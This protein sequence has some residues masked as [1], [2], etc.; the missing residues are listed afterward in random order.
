VQLGYSLP[1]SDV[2]QEFTEFSG[3]RYLERRVPSDISNIGTEYRVT[4]MLHPDWMMGGVSGRVYEGGQFATGTLTWNSTDDSLAWLLVSG[5]DKLEVVVYANSMQIRQTRTSTCIVFYV[6]CHNLA[7][8]MINGTTWS[9]PGITLKIDVD[10][11]KISTEVVDRNQFRA[12]FEIRESVH[13]IVK[14]TCLTD[15]ISLQI[16]T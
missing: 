10:P 3:S 2:L 5:K 14:V 9:L 1:S 4:A 7:T 16:I 13:D 11:S 8:G 12:D 15:Q 6:N